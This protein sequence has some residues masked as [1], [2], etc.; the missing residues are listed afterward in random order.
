MVENRLVEQNSNT[1]HCHY[2]LPLR[3]VDGH[4]ECWSN[5]KCAI[6]AVWT[7]GGP[8]S[9]GDSEMHGMLPA[10]AAEMRCSASLTQSSRMFNVA[11]VG[12]TLP[13]QSGP[14]HRESLRPTIFPSPRSVDFGTRAMLYGIKRWALGLDLGNVLAYVETP[15]HVQRQAV[16]DRRVTDLRQIIY[17]SHHVSTRKKVEVEIYSL[18]THT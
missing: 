6:G 17:R 16:I 12:R 5:W 13:Q 15:P 1:L 9:A 4:C 2:C 14:Q 7:A 8:V 11:R 10:A 18:L 3:L